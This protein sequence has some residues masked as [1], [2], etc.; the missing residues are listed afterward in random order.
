MSESESLLALARSCALEAARLAARS[1][2]PER[3]EHDFSPVLAREVKSPADLLLE[4]VILGQL[5]PTGIPVLSEE[6]GRLEGERPGA[7]VFIVDPLDG[8]A[9]YVRGIG[10]SAVSIALWE[11]ER[12]VFGVV[13]V[14]PTL[15]LA[16]GGPGM[17]AT[18]GGR[19]MQVSR[20]EDRSRAILCTGFPARQDLDSPEA[21]ARFFA[22]VRP[23][24]KV[25]M[26]GAASIA[27]L[28][29]ARGAADAYAEEEVMLWDVAAG[30]AL[31]LG[32]GGRIEFA[33]GRD[34][35]ALRVRADNG[36]LART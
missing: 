24:A 33:P 6:A 5:R 9:N 12:P 27:L 19:P 3:R 13:C 10:H 11:G 28:Q 22:A 4:K 15:E 17:G 26:L 7:R 2:E 29:V 31:V 16:W 25:R 18:L 20:I 23:Y 36:R 32:A 21:P 8:T 34:P 1:S 14:I 35:H 30:L